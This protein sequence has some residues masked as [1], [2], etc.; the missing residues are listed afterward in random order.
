[1]ARYFLCLISIDRWMITS[2]QVSIRQLSSL[3]IVRWLI[4]FGTSFCAI[5]SIN[6]PIWYRIEGSKGC[7]GATDTFYPLFY[8]IYNLV[9]TIGPF[10]IMIF[11]SLLALR[12]FQQVRHRRVVAT[13]QT[14]ESALSLNTGRHFQRKDLQFIKLSLIQ[15]LIYILFNTFY[16]YNATYA[17]MTQS[18]VKSPD[19]AA[20]DSFLSTIGL[21]ISYLYMAVRYFQFIKDKNFLSFIF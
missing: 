19:R 2:T 5:V 8:T 17:F 10:C 3:K 21:I 15:V 4:I 1:M 12:N 14:D 13:A 9:I 16:A 20:F 7:I 18:T 6:F 11:F